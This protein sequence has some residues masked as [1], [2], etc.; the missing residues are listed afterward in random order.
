MFSPWNIISPSMRA[1]IM[2]SFIRFRQRMSVL[3]P[4]PDGPISAVTCRDKN[5]IVT[6][7]T[8]WWDPYQTFKSLMSNPD[9][10]PSPGDFTVG[11]A[12]QGALLSSHYHLILPR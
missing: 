7:P 3:L 4:H 8:A 12:G 5:W 2:R 6:G 1:L 9:P 11:C 10:D